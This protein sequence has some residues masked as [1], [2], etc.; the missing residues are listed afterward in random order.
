[1]SDQARP[2]AEVL[3][4]AKRAIAFTG[5]GISTESGIPDF[6]GPQGIWTKI[7][8]ADFT[9]ENYLYNDEHRRRIWRFRLEN[10]GAR[11][12]PNAGHRALADLERLGVLDCVVTQNIDGL[13]IEAGNTTVLE[14]HGHGRSV[15][16]LG[17][18]DEHPSG[19]IL[20]RVRAGDDDPHCT[21][22]GGLLKSAT[23][24]FGEPLPAHVV[25][26]SFARAEACDVCLVVG[27]SLV[28][29]PAAG[30]PLAAVRAGARLA[31][32]NEE[33]TPLDGEAELVIRGRAG[34]IL[35]DA[36]AAVREMLGV[37]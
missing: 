28:V 23:I 5:A 24:S 25:D 11:Y 13:H 3:A 6:R 19:E 12:E 36:I 2:L 37:Q 33:P 22:C 34:S 8:P 4:A 9:L 32:V 29:Y 7:D 18:G 10:K 26:E 17:C 1:M 16:C 31:I 30:I 20:E 27:S 14:L 15:R 35:T 21:R